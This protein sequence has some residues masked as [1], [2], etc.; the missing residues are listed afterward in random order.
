MADVNSQ[1]YWAPLIITVNNPTG[2]GV[3]GAFGINAG[4]TEICSPGTEE[5]RMMKTGSEF[6]MGIWFVNGEAEWNVTCAVSCW[7]DVSR[8]DSLIEG[9]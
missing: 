8:V 6:R 5:H 4:G 1:T 3:C 9:V 7:I 2:E